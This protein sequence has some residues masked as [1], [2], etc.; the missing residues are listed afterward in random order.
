MLEELGESAV[1]GSDSPIE[2]E[3]RLFSFIFTPPLKT[4][5]HSEFKVFVTLASDLLDE[6]VS[7]AD[8]PIDENISPHL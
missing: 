4:E 3:T 1:S 5:C 2:M 6:S 7:R 8:S